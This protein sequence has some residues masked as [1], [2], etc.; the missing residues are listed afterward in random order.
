MGHLL[1][2]L[3]APQLLGDL[4]IHAFSSEADVRLV[5]GADDDPLTALAEHPGATVVTLDPTGAEAVVHRAGGSRPLAPVSVRSL[6]D[7][8]RHHW[9]AG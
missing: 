6:L 9:T 8:A 2:V 7:A 1:I 5:V 4:L 3:G